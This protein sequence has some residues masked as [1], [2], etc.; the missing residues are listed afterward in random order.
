MFNFKFLFSICFV[1][2]TGCVQVPRDGDF[3]AVK[4]LTSAR[5]PQ[6]I[7][8]YQG[9]QEDDQVRAT[10]DHLLHEPLTLQSAVQIALLNNQDLQAEYEK[11]GIAQA[12][13]V[14]AGLLSNPVLFASIRFPKGGAGGHNTEFV[15]AKEFL[16]ILLRSSRQHLAGEEFERVKLN[17]SKSVMDLVKNVQIAFYRVQGADKLLK[18]N[19][20]AWEAASATFDFAQRFEDAGNISELRLAQERSAA[21]E[22]TAEKI[23]T[24]Q[25]LNNARDKLNALLGLAGADNQWL[26]AEELPYLPD[27]DPELSVLETMALSQRLDLAAAQL[28]VE[29][30]A[31]A[32]DM[33]RDYRWIGGATVGVS[34]ERD[35]DG[36]RVTGPNF[37]VEIPVFDQRQAEIARL[38]SFLAQS[39]TRLAAQKTAALNEVQT[40]W[41][42]VS[43]SR[44][45]S[46]YYRDEL[47]PA[48]EQVVKFTQQYQNYMLTDVFE[49]LYARQQQTLAYRGYIE[50]LTDYWIARTELAHAAGTGLSA[51]ENP[52]LSLNKVE[53]D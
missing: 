28:E 3:N 11:L 40:A 38:E 27:N 42:Q 33:T 41:N 23:R 5:L 9:G 19:E 10:L 29:Q 15:I 20:V 26:L 52:D 53:N 21:A 36:S 8:W 45:I 4:D 34:T 17:V 25:S 7:H 30:M 44:S 35:T 14:Q 49:L 32:L 46:E 12:E 47:I 1:F 31:Y 43:S 13:L 50:S 48:R 22:I 6:T 18:I 2:L 37:S 51:I 16:D 39:K 24:R